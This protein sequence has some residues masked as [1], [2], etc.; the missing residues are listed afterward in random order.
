[1]GLRALRYPL[2]LELGPMTDLAYGMPI[3]ALVDDHIHSAR[4]LSRTLAEADTPARVRWLGSELRALRSLERLLVQHGANVPDMIVVDLKSHS[5]ASENFIV[6][7]AAWARTAG[8]P[9]VAI[10]PSLDA[11][12]RNGLLAAGAAAV[13]ER[14]HDLNIYRREMEQ[15]PAFWVRETATWPIR[16]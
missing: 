4:L 9:I 11:G 5:G 12:V 3:F 14:H 10:A 15:L 13:F 2:L 16:A 8:T 6:R 1:M 7:I